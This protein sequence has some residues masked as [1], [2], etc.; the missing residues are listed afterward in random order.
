MN[1]LDLALLGI[2][3]LSLLYSTWKG[4][5]RDVFSLAGLIGG[6]FVA[7]HFYALFAAWLTRWISTPLLANLLAWITLF[8]M[9]Y[10]VTSLLGRMLWGGLKSLRL[11]WFDRLVGLMFGFVKGILLCAGLLL[12]LVAFL[13]AHAP[14]LTGSRLAPHVIGI[15]WELGRLV[16][17]KLGRQI[18]RA[19]PPRD[20]LDKKDERDVDDAPKKT[21]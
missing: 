9:T 15:S 17:G 19:Q 13:P 14:L 21:R 7:F 10:L 8:L 6:F 11:G 5:V 18:R 2:M 12:V 1:L 3:V 4:F 16:P 20:A